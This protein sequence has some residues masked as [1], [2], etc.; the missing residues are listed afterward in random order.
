MK[1]P[2]HVNL[3]PAIVVAGPPHSGKSVL[4]FLL[5]ERLR[6]LGVS[7]YLLRAVPDGEGNW[8]LQGPQDQVWEMR[9]RHKTGYSDAFV[10]HMLRVLQRRTLPL[11]VDIGGRPTG[12]QLQL[13]DACTHCILLYKSAQERQEWQ[14]LLQGMNLLP[15]ALLRSDLAGEDVLEEQAGVLGGLIGGLERQPEGRRTGPVFNALLD[16]V[17]GI[18]EYPQ[19]DLEAWHW[20]QAPLPVLQE[21]AL[22]QALGLPVQGTH[23]L[24][25]HLA[26]LPLA[27][28]RNEKGWALYGRGPVWLAAALAAQ[29]APRPFA[30]F[31][32]RLGWV[33]CARLGRRREGVLR[34]AW[35]ELPAGDGLRLE[36]T[37][38]EGMLEAEQFSFPRLPK[39]LTGVVLSG[40]L[41]RWA[42]AALA[43]RLVQRGALWLAVQDMNVGRAMVVFSRSPAHRVGEWVT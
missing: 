11:L 4:N 9:M 37:L 1:N 18:F 43:R 19:Q 23:W 2:V 28:L 14:S 29:T 10:Q 5:T 33:N 17:R 26:Q 3:L 38:L 32:V 22:A 24:P 7:H 35:V 41:P 20:A 42:F 6:A 25:Q 21:S 12:M 15:I 27:E 13:L 36:V 40:K 16:R 31:D 39:P 8:F 30:V 34:Y